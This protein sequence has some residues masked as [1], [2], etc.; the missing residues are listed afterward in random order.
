MPDSLRGDRPTQPDPAQLYELL[1]AELTDFAVFL[2]DPTG[3][4]TTWNPGVE[5]LLGYSEAE[6]IGQPASIIFTPEDRAVGKPEEEMAIAV[7]NG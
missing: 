1:I 2:T 4:L 3:S 7:R 5:T 6:W